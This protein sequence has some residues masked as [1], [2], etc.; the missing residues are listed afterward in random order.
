MRLKHLLLVVQGLPRRKAPSIP[1]QPRHLTGQ[2]STPAH[3]RS[4][5]LPTT[6]SLISPRHHILHRATTCKNRLA[7]HLGRAAGGAALASWRSTYRSV[8]QVRRSQLQPLVRSTDLYLFK[9][10]MGAPAPT[11]LQPTGRTRGRASVG[12]VLALSSTRPRSFEFSVSPKLCGV[13]KLDLTWPTVFPIGRWRRG[14]SGYLFRG[15][16]I[17]TAN[18]TTRSKIGS[19]K[20][21]LIRPIIYYQRLITGCSLK[22]D[23]RVRLRQGRLPVR[24]AIRSPQYRVWDR[25]VHGRGW[26]LNV[27][28][29]L[30]GRGEP[31]VSKSRSVHVQT[32]VPLTLFLIKRRPRSAGSSAQ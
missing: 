4:F 29:R 14:R 25:S 5:R 23:T 26:S 17:S 22:V 31:S 32:I 10:A 21:C 7:S 24:P 11:G 18:I 8:N 2:P 16:R 27:S 15:R 3:P 13:V 1:T 19:Y 6:T 30:H 12:S 9:A 28:V 20:Q